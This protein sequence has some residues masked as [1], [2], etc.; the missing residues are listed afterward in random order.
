MRARILRVLTGLAALTTLIALVAGLPIM[1]YRFGGS[2]LP[3]HLAGWHRLAAI[4]SSRDDGSVLLMVIK[5]CSWL[6]WL[7][8]TLCVLAEVQAAVRGR[9]GA[10]LRLGGVQNVAARLVALAALTFAAPPALALTASATA[11]STPHS[12]HSWPAEE[13]AT[14]A[15]GSRARPGTAGSPDAATAQTMAT[16]LITIRAGDCLWSIA[17]R[18]LGSGERYGE[19]AGLNYGRDMGDG[20]VFTNPALIVPGWR[21]LLP[22]MATASGEIAA[23]GGT[24]ASGEASNGQLPGRYRRHRCGIQRH[25]R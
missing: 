23:S 9:G 19:I 1:L 13:T 2:P 7:I 18:Y 5:D 21:L 3:R 22:G 6:A 14:A 25:R 24:S 17:Q 4:L 20:Q 8:F 10:R 16:R 11:L 15:G 12:T